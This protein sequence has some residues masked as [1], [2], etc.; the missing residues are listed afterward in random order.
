MPFNFEAL[1]VTETISIVVKRVVTS[2]PIKKPKP[3]VEFFRIRPGSEWKFDTYLLD[4]GGKGD[5]EG[6]FLL[7]PA[8]YPEVIETKKLRLVRIY[9]GITYGSGEIFLSEIPKP[10][11]DGKDHEYN[12]TR[13]LAYTAAETQWLKLQTNDSIGAYDMILSM[14]KLPDPEWP[15]EPENMVKAIELAFK[16]K[17]IDD[18]NH[19]VLKKLRGEL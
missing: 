14:S 4:L 15:E 16:D 3:G 5:G 2:I 8:L 17:F 12:R 7:D 19:P 9:A 1:Q 13:R 6:K 11:A 18:H 10:D